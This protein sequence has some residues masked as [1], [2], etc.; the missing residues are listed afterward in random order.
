MLARLF[1]RPANLL[2][3]DEPTNDLDIDTLEILENL[4]VAY[5]GTL[6]LISHDRQFIDNVVTSTLVFEGNG[7][8]GEYVGGFDD[9]R[10][11]SVGSN[12][13]S[14]RIPTRKARKPAAKKKTVA[15]WVTWSPG[16]W[17]A[18][19]GKSNR[20]KN[21]KK[22][23]TPNYAIPPSTKPVGKTLPAFKAGSPIWTKNWKR[24]TGGGKS[25]KPDR[26]K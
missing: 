4:L 9:W 20:S 1:T 3:L 14:S 8:I 23:C 26:I 12:P 25:W 16:N 7:K 6:L 15:K 13:D 5:A 10:R 21:T 19:P 24:P 2:I 17:S 22:C 11:Q 18:C